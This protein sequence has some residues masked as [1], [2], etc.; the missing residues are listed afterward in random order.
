MKELKEIYKSKVILAPMAGVTDKA[1]RRTVRTIFDGL[2]FT[3]MISTKALFYNDKKTI[4]LMDIKDEIHPIGIQLFGH[5]VE[6]F[7]NACNVIKD[8]FDI[9]D[10]NFGCP[11]PKIVK[12]GD[13]SRL[14]DDLKLSRKIIESVVKHSK[15]PVTVKMRR[16]Y[17]SDNYLEFAKMAEK[18]GASAITVHPRFRDEFYM[19]KANREVIKRIKEE[20]DIPVIGNGDIDSISSAD[21]MFNKTNCDYIMVGRHALGNPYFIK[22]L[23]EYY[24]NKI[25]LNDLKLE[26]KINIILKHVDFMIEHKGE[27]IGIIELR[28]HLLW[29]MKGFKNSKKLKNEI[30]RITKKSELEVILNKLEDK[31]SKIRRVEKLKSVGL[32]I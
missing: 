24:K 19:G 8:R 1:F 15:V 32:K 29:Y 25:V 28:K 31:S 10:I 20:I 27:E 7:I 17:S 11:A 30:S 9:I 6:P 22:V 16:G 26:Q 13:G 3:E 2:I 5:E 18:A 4:E 12:N 23:D 14:M 21:D